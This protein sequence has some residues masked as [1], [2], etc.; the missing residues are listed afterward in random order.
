[1][2]EAQRGRRKMKDSMVALKRDRIV[3]VAA[4]LFYERGFTRTTL[5]DVA[6]RLGVTKP[7]IYHSFGSKT[8]L[9]AEICTRGVQA[10]LTEIE[11]VQ[12]LDLP[13]AETLRRF[14]PRY[15]AAVLRV[16][17]MIAINIREEKNLEPADAERLAALRQQFMARMEA[18]LR[19]G[20][21]S[22]EIR[23]PDPRIAAFTLVGA[24]SWTTFWYNPGGVFSSDVIAQRMAEVALNLLRIETPDQ[25]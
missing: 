6:E 25:A 22:G 4:D 16:Q 13:P 20:R 11:Q 15:V 8:E 3:D 18:I 10:A 21:E 2:A 14:M 1:M 23:V 17:K 19:A 5:D 12:A 9:L 24:A 7:F